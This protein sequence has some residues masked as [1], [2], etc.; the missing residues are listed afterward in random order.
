MADDAYAEFR[1][2]YNAPS[3]FL[4]ATNQRVAEHPDDP[5][6]YFARHQAWERLGQLDLA[7]ADI[8]KSLALEDHFTTHRARGG[9]LRLMGRHRD[10]IDAYNRS[11]QM[12]PSEWKSGF[13][14]LFRADCYARLGDEAAALADC[15]SLP[16]DH[17]APGLFGAPAGN[18]K[19]VAA[20]LR[21]RAALRRDKH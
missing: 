16:D 6:A 10:A 4:E 18:K 19:E 8:E 12:A 5:N 15:N 11:E 20:E 14:P 21:R 2:L 9:I 3:Q 1:R 13:G 7:L 17:W